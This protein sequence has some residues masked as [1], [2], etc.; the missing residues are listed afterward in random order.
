MDDVPRYDDVPLVAPGRRHVT[1]VLHEERDVL[2]GCAFGVATRQF[3]GLVS[4]VDAAEGGPREA[5]GESEHR[6]T[7]ATAHVTHLHPGLYNTA[8]IRTDGRATTT[9]EKGGERGVGERREERGERREERGE[10]REERGE[11]RE[12]RGERREERGERREERGERREERGE[13]REERGERREE[14]GERIEE[15][16]ERKERRET[17]RKGERRENRRK[18]REEREERDR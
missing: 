13:R 1:H 12:E 15:R 11:R 6:L 8:R 4:D 18:R 3:D 2:Q 9:G 5:G 16:E 17:D 7:A 10:R 14:R